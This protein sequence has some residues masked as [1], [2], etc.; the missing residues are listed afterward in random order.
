MAIDLAEAERI[1]KAANANPLA[2]VFFTDSHG[3]TFSQTNNKAFKSYA[4]NHWQE[5][6]DELRN[7]RQLQKKVAHG[8]ADFNC[9]LCD[10]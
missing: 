9:E 5:M 1:W 4:R 8:C 7:Y 10:W 2:R 6:V 3:R